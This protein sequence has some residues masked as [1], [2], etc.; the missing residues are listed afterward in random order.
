[1]K[2]TLISNN[3]FSVFGGYE[4]VVYSVFKVLTEKYNCEVSIISLPHYSSLLDFPILEDF[5][6]FKISRTSDYKNKIYYLIYILSRRFF[7]RKLLINYNSIKKYLSEIVSSDIVLVT[8]PL[9]VTSVKF[10]IQK[11]QISAKIVYWDHGSLFGYLRGRFQ[12]IIY[13][14][15]IFEALKSADAHLAI[16][17][18]MAEAVKNIDSEAKV[19]IVYNPVSVYNGKLIQR[20]LSPIFLYVGR[21]TDQDKNISF[22]LTGL[23]KLGSKEWQ[24]KIIGSGKDE[25]KLKDL[26]KK[27]NISNKIEWLGFRKDPYDE[28]EEATAL[29]LTSRWEGFPMVL[30]E[31][32]QRGIPVI[33]SDCKA[34]PKGIV[35][36]GKNGYLYKEGDMNDFVKIV[37]GVIDRRLQFDTPENIAKTAERFREDIVISNIYNSLKRVIEEDV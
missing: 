14:R 36:S 16:S 11:N 32:N 1:M 10:V 4:K 33:S 13:S 28:I 5:K 20:P 6:N 17:T 37:S 34:G 18:E 21:L 29:L 22:L 9:L 31:A 23:S 25:N 2:I 12:R 24:L 15:E 30:V 35:I 19:Y 27:L 7:N 8:D 3:T 26:A